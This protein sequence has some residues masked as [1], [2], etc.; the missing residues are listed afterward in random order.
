MQSLEQ[1]SKRKE[2]IKLYLTG[3]YTL[4]DIAVKIGIS[5]VSASKWH[6]EIPA[7]KYARIRANLSKELERLSQSPNGREELIFNYIDH[8]NLLDTMIR[9][10]KYNPF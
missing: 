3:K 2:F 10:A 9:K 4:K 7:V 6:K 5:S 8:I 1:T